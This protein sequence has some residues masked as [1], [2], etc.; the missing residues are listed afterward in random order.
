MSVDQTKKHDWKFRNNAH[1]Y[2][3]CNG[4][5][6]IDSVLGVATPVENEQ[7]VGCVHNKF[8]TYHVFDSLAQAKVHIEAL[9]CL[10][11]DKHE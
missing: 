6:H 10:E 5:G 4:L 7:F 2:C 8:D 11:G 3:L 9:V 1:F